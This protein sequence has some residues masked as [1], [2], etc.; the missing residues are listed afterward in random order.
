MQT[1]DCVCVHVCTP[2]VFYPIAQEI[3]YQGRRMASNITY[4]PPPPHL[5][6]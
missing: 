4:V 6:V 5:L 3:T 1:Y 2:C